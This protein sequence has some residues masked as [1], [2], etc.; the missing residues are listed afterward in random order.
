MSSQ[1]NLCS[2]FG[3]ITNNPLRW[4]VFLRAS[5]YIF[6]NVY[7][8]FTALI[9]VVF[10]ATVGRP[11][12]IIIII[13]TIRQQ[14]WVKYRC[15][16]CTCVLAGPTSSRS[17]TESTVRNPSKTTVGLPPG[18]ILFSLALRPY[19][20]MYV[21]LKIVSSNR[22]LIACEAQLVWKCLFISLFS[23]SDLTSKVRQTDLF[24]A[25]G[26]IS[27]SVRTRL[28][29]SVCSGYDLCYS[30]WP[31]IWLNFLL[32]WPWKVGQIWDESVS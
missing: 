24:L 19:P 20:S 3:N 8:Q 9:P 27:R 5:L 29:V 21:W 12:S 13:I 28:Q 11:Y 1:H 25:L 15:V 17:S 6:L 30:S 7:S 2:Y 22:H 4:Y 14:T 18:L 32:L 16:N 31:K 23:P 26:F 10:Y